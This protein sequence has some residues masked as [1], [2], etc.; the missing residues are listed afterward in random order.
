MLD[1]IGVD[2]LLILF[3][4]QLEVV[5]G[6]VEFAEVHFELDGGPEF[7]A[8]LG[9]FEEDA[10]FIACLVEELLRPAFIDGVQV[11][12]SPWASA[13]NSPREEQAEERRP[14]KIRE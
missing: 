4:H 10:I 8:G 3:E 11:G 9:L 12:L 2:L 6:E 14:I 13:G 5:G 1:E 7:E